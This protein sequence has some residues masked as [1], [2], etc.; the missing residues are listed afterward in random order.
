MRNVTPQNGAVWFEIPVW[1]CDR[2]DEA[3]YLLLLGS[4]PGTAAARPAGD[5]PEF[6]AF[7]DGEGRFAAPGLPPGEYWVAAAGAL[8]RDLGGEWQAPH[9]V[10][11]RLSGVDSH[12]AP[13]LRAVAVFGAEGRRLHADRPHAAFAPEHSAQTVHGPQEVAAVLLH[14]REEQV[15]ASVAA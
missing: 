3:A 10:A 1:P 13:R 8:E 4:Y 14:H 11:A 7:S 12:L 2:A 9:L 15:G 6:R 5:S